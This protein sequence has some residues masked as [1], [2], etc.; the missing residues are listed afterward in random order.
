MAFFRVVP[1]DEA[2]QVQAPI[3]DHIGCFR[4]TDVRNENDH[5]IRADCLFDHNG[6]VVRPPQQQGGYGL[7]LFDHI[8][9]DWVLLKAVQ[10]DDL[11]LDARWI[12]F[13]IV[14]TSAGRGTMAACY[15]IQKTE[16]EEGLAGST[17]AITQTTADETHFS[18]HP[19]ATIEVVMVDS[20]KTHLKYAH[21]DLISQQNW[22]AVGI[23]L[24]PPTCAEVF[25]R[26]LH[27]HLQETDRMISFVIEECVEVLEAHLN[28]VVSVTLNVGWQFC[29]DEIFVY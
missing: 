17:W 24:V 3:R 6:I 27:Q 29:M 11:F 4:L 12:P 5:K 19:T 20:A 23:M 10:G 7:S 14:L 18:I 9:N 26:D 8:P 13:G 2:H 22:Q 28:E 25:G 16:L 1:F 21:V 15:Q